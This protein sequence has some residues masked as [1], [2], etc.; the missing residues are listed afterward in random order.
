MAGRFERAVRHLKMDFHIEYVKLD[1]VVSEDFIPLLNKEN[2]RRHLVRHDL[3][4]AEMVKD[5]IAGKVELD[6]S[7]GCKIRAVLIDS[8]LAGWCGIQSEDGKYEIAIVIDDRYW[9][10]GVKIFRDVMAWAEELGH[11]T[12]FIHFLYSRPE[13]KFLRKIARN[14]FVSEFLGSQFTTYELEVEKV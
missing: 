9:G 2:L 1:E 11:K 4:N 13:Y 7:E 6:S 12:V 3:F 10:V 14:V 8:Q 5:W